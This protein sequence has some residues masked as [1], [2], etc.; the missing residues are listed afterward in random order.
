MQI[1]FKLKWL[2]GHMIRS[3]PGSFPI[4]V[5][6]HVGN[7]L[8]DKLVPVLACVVAATNNHAKQISTNQNP[9]FNSALV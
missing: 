7:V 8:E 2:Q 9:E 1:Q 3:S 5:T 6:F 4:I